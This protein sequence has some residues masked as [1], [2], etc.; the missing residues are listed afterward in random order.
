M[1]EEGELRFPIVCPKR[2]A[3]TLERLLCKILGHRRTSWSITVEDGRVTAISWYCGRC[4][5]TEKSPVKG[6][7]DR[8]DFA[9]GLA[10]AGLDK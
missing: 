4:G 1:T 8:M 6:G 2:N 10:F 7:S 9:V 5:K 3:T